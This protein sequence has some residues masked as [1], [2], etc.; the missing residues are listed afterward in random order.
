MMISTKKLRIS[1]I[2]MWVYSFRSLFGDQAMLYKKT[3]FF[4]FIVVRNYN[5]TT[6]RLLQKGNKNYTLNRSK[7]KV[8]KI[9]SKLRIYD[10][11]KHIEKILKI[12]KK[13]KKMY[14]AITFSHQNLD[15]KNCRLVHISKFVQTHNLKF[16]FDISVVITQLSQTSF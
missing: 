9:I 13:K 10:I 1:V 11:Q 5:L 12:K 8:Y 14:S 6:L 3:F 15:Q 4:I 2:F 7:F 16:L